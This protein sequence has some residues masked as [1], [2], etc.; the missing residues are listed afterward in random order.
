MGAYMSLLW[1][2]SFKLNF[3]SENSNLHVAWLKR[4][5]VLLRRLKLVK[6]WVCQ[7]K[8]MQI[9]HLNFWILKQIS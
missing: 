3:I 8:I 7:N 5:T 6:R 9:F 1:M 2:F 4:N